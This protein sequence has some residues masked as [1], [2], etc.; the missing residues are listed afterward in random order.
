M[1]LDEIALQIWVAH[2]MAWYGK[3]DKWQIEES[4]RLATMF[5]AQIKEGI[6]NANTIQKEE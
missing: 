5:V 3:T 2:R 4:I 1:N 6:R